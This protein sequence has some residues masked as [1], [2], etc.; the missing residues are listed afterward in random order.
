MTMAE[1]KFYDPFFEPD[2][3]LIYSVISARYNGKWIF[4][5]HQNRTTWEIPGGHIEPGESSDEAA[6]RELNEETGAVDFSIFRLATYSVTTD[7]TTLYGRLYF[8]E[9]KD[10]GPIPDISEINEI[11][12]LDYIPDNLTHPQIQPSLFRKTIEY[13]S[14][15][16]G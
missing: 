11:T 15:I 12:F 1:I 5:R 13:L 10:I 14:A 8:A 2:D 9:V 6:S 16:R 4:V 7:G 3:N